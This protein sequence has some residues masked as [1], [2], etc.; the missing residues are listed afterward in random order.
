MAGYSRLEQEIRRLQAWGAF[1]A[2]TRESWIYS[3]VLILFFVVGFGI[4]IWL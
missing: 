1:H 3:I 2:T 4:A